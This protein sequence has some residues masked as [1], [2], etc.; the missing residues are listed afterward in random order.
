MDKAQ[1]AY[2]EAQQQMEIKV[3][4]IDAMLG[5]VSGRVIAG[6]FDKNAADEQRSADQFRWASLAC[7]AVVISTIAFTFLESGSS[8]FDWHLGVVRLAMSFVLFVPAGYLARESAKHRQ[9]QHAYLQAALCLKTIPPYIASLPDEQQHKI[10]AEMAQ[11][12]FSFGVPAAGDAFGIP[13]VHD[14]SVELIRRVEVPKPK[15]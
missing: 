5:H 9:Q 8:S 6:D 14:L 3:K 11:K 12:V 10:K 13:N 4:E 1:A 15:A 2:A 7:M